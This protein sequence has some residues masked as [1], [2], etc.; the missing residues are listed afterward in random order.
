MGSKIP[1]HTFSSFSFNFIGICQKTNFVNTGMKIY[2][3]SHDMK[4]DIQII[5]KRLFVHF[6]ALRFFPTNR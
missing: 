5:I 6:I 4:A 1:V 2:K 3:I